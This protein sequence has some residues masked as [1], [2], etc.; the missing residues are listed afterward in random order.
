MVRREA[1]LTM[2]PAMLDNAVVVYK[3]QK[4]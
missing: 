2:P 3:L 4:K 1:Y